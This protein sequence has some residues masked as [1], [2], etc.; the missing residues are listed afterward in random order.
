MKATFKRVLRGW[1]TATAA[2]CSIA[3]VVGASGGRPVSIEERMKG[4]D[5]VVVATALAVEPTWMQNRHG[6]RLIVS[7]VLLEVEETLKGGNEGVLSFD[8]EGGTLDGLTLTVSDL[9]QMKS[10]QRAVFFLSG[11]G[12]TGLAPFQRGAGILKLDADG[13]VSGSGIR[14]SDIRSL[15]A[16]GRK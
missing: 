9:P 15:A 14:L 11:K 5:R 7:R 12:S 4:A 6:D 13:A 3:V 8:L 10:G 16:A 2:W 1:L